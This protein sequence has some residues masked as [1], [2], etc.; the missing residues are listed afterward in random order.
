MV[1]IATATDT[2]GSIRIPGAFCG[3]A[4]LKPTRGVVA[5]DP[6]LCWPHLTTSGP[7]AVGVDDLRSLLAVEAA[8]PPADFPPPRRVIAVPRFGRASPLPTAV[9]DAFDGALDRLE[10]ELGLPVERV[11]APILSGDP[12]DVW[13]A[14]T[15][16]E[17]VAWLGRERAQASLERM[18]PTTRLFVEQGLRTTEDRYREARRHASRFARE[19]DAVLADGGVIATPTLAA[20][21]W[22]PEGPM[23]DSDEP[24]PP[25]EVFNTGVQNLTGHPAITVPAG[26]F[27]NGVPFGLQLTGPTFGDGLLL[28]VAEAWERARR[29]PVAAEGYEPFAV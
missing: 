5:R 7:L 23:P 27:A 14:W 28:D 11:D 13:G 22:L 6:A 21:G 1:P 26:R 15:A 9:A 12:E 25:G 17:L 19:L 4:G 8:A 29:W 3:L 24:G 10:R 20:D 18:Y 2:G 16:P